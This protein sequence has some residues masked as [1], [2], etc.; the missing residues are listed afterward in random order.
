MKNKIK[1]I[2]VFIIYIIV[3]SVNLLDSIKYPDSEVGLV[4]IVVSVFFLI[5]IIWFTVYQI[6]KNDKISSIL[7]SGAVFG[8][9]LVY[10]MEHFKDIMLNNMILDIFSNI[11]IP[12]FILFITPLFGL[13][14]FL[15]VSYGRFS[16][17]MSIIYFS[18]LI[19]KFLFGKKYSGSK[20]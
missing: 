1:Y 13:N 5:V 15:N 7:L 10:A 4:N 6:N 16:I 19:A 8:G 14:F 12:F 3:I 2:F 11:Q 17:I 20:R 9:I 18:I